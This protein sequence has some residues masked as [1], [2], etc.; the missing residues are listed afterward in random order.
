M[1][2]TMLKSKVLAQCLLWDVSM[3]NTNSVELGI[4]KEPR[5]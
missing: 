2:T 5:K 1:L 4:V 3:V